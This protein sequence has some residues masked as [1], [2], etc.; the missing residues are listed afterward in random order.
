MRMGW[1]FNWVSSYANEFTFDY[2]ASFTP[3]DL[4]KG[5]VFYNFTSTP[6]SIE[7]LSGISVFYK[8]RN[9][10]V[11]HTY[12]SYARGMRKGLAPTCIWTL[13]R[14]AAMK[15]AP[16][17]TCPTGYGTTTGTVRA[18]TSMPPGP[19]SP[20]KQDRAVMRRVKTKGKILRKS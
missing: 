1:R 18:A 20:R 4:A 19:S 8:D 12:S 2:H 11:F 7:D 3:D 6:A 9:G 16:I 13:R 15:P 5:E 14:E 17:T 10:D